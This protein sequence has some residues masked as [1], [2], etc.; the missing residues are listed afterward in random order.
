MTDALLARSYALLHELGNSMHALRTLD[1]LLGE[2]PDLTTR[3]VQEFMDAMT[4]CCS[5][6]KRKLIRGVIHAHFAALGRTLSLNFPAPCDSVTDAKSPDWAFNTEKGLSDANKD[7]LLLDVDESIR[8]TK[9][10]YDSTFS[11]I[12]MKYREIYSQHE[13]FLTACEALLNAFVV[14]YDPDWVNEK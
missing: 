11:D 14:V 2:I 10:K 6:S 5:H 3:Q 1:V 13:L 9:E 7:R 12:V 8:V 4:V